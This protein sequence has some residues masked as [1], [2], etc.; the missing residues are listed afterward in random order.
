MQL[1]LI[2]LQTALK[3]YAQGWEQVQNDKKEEHLDE[4]TQKIAYVKKKRISNIL[5]TDVLA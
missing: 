1:S 3:K 5:E 4:F 2:Q